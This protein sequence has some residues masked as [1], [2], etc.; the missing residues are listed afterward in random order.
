MVKKY[1]TLAN[2]IT[3]GRLGLFGWALWLLAQGDTYQAIILFAIAWGLD[4]V[5]GL[6]ARFLGQASEFGSQFDKI[7]DRIIV[8]LGLLAFIRLGLLPRAAILILTKDF[9]LVPLMT[10]LAAEKRNDP[11]LGQF[12][13]TV[14]LLQGLSILVLLL[15]FARGYEMFVIGFA[16]VV[17]FAA[18]YLHYL[19][20]LPGI[21]R[22]P[23]AGPRP[24][25]GS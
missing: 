11:G 16:A 18:A 4:A 21:S 7:V 23:Q 19:K 24:R 5:D 25:R 3:V 6:A 1:V 9:A 15:G 22:R 14:T 13:K 8:G 12:G 2:G 20:V 10:I 17:G